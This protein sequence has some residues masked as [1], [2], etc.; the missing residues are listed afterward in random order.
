MPAVSFKCSAGTIPIKTCIQA[1]PNPAGRC[2][3]LPTLIEVG[4]SREYRG[5]FSTTLLLMPTRQAYL[6]LTADY[7]IDPSE[8]AFLLLGTKAHRRLEQV[9]KKVK[10]LQSEMPITGEVNSTL[11]LLEPLPDGT[12]RLVDYKTAG[13]FAIQKMLDGDFGTYAMQVNHYRLQAESVSF[14]VSQMFIQYIARDFTPRNN[15]PDVAKMAL[16]K[17]PFMDNAFVQ[18]YFDNARECLEAAMASGELPPICE[19]RW[20]SDGRCKSYCSVNTVC[21][22]GMK[23]IE[24]KAKREAQNG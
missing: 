3:S 2:L 5:S 24:A 18:G 12:Y 20:N 6:T 13:S 21:P 23:Y 15:L 1:C 4:W 14:P 16:V 10:E 8:S 22:H 7:A 17:V 19:D 11:D 9:A